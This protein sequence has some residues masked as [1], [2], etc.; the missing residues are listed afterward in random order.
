MKNQPSFFKNL[1]K[2]GFYVI[3]FL[4]ITAVG[5]AGYVMFQPNEKPEDLVT[6]DSMSQTDSG[7][8][9]DSALADK[10]ID[11]PQ[12]PPKAEPQPK[13]STDVSKS[14][15]P[16][17]ST[18]KKQV[19]KKAVAASKSIVLDSEPTSFV[20]AVSGKIEVPFSGDELVKS[21][22]FG[23]WRTHSGIDISAK[24]GTK[25]CAIAKGVV[26]KVYAD[27]MMGHT[28]IIEHADGIQSTYCNLMKGIVVKVGQK[29]NAGDVIGGVGTSAVAECIQS[30]HLHL[31]VSKNG[32]LVDP[33]SIIK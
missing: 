4:C 13:A 24:E 6:T 11:I 28:V 26:K 2:N 5:V 21:Q 10:P 27:E 17:K 32:K 1:S 29:V 8:D 30:P 18:V 31:E 12:N 7:Y 3:L 16:A 22:T 23:D 19:P 33:I 25:V 20:S 9:F 14:T 15:A